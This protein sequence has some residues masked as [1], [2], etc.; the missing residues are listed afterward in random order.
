MAWI[1]CSYLGADLGQVTNFSESLFLLNDCI[2]FLWLKS[3]SEVAQSCLPLCNSMDCSLPGSSVH[4]IFP[5]RVLEWV[6]IFFSRGS[7]WPRDRTWVSHV[8]GRRFTVCMTDVT[9]KFTKHFMIN[10]V[11][12]IN[13][14][15]VLVIAFLIF[16]VFRFQRQHYEP[17]SRKLE[18]LR[19]IALR[20][21]LHLPL[22]EYPSQILCWPLNSMVNCCLSD[23]PSPQCSIANLGN[24]SGSRKVHESS[25]DSWLCPSEPH[26]NMWFYEL[27]S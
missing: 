6:A 10:T 1:L 26:K 17:S 2:Y 22:L 5:A 14:Q 12:G 21:Y 19:M 15:Y 16:P 24:T 3:E 18:T 4:G 11:L 13:P 8:A 20:A 7:S 27:I 9:I 23:F 25:W